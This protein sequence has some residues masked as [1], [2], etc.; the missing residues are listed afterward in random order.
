MSK[1]QK[2]Y[3]SEKDTISNNSDLPFDKLIMKAENNIYEFNFENEKSKESL[4]K[5][6]QRM[7]SDMPKDGENNIPIQYKPINKM[8]KGQK[9]MSP[10]KE[11]VHVESAE[12]KGEKKLSKDYKN[13]IQTSKQNLNEDIKRNIADDTSSD[14]TV[15]IIS[16]KKLLNIKDE[17]ENE[18]MA[19]NKNI[20]NASK[21]K[22]NESSN[23]V[24]P[25]NNDFNFSF[26][27]KYNN[28]MDL[29]ENEEI[30][31]KLFEYRKKKQAV[32]EKYNNIRNTEEEKYKN[33]INTEEEKYKNIINNLEK[34]YRLE[35]DGLEINFI[36]EL[37]KIHK[38]PNDIIQKQK[39]N[40]KNPL[41]LKRDLQDKQD[42][43]C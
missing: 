13:E 26:V 43:D 7:K 34:N 18:I 15:E 42:K 31:E 35:I 39:E 6:K 17:K 5:K 23:L 25:Q 3:N 8:N 33:I 2:D 9:H 24:N 28:L 37:L 14:S 30:Q 19:T 32:E 38:D 27:D 21:L 36:K 41:G 22:I 40:E 4:D 10:K 20:D 1:N 29:N 12:C 16:S 11:K